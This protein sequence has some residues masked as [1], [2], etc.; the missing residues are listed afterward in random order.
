M[1]EG[2]AGLSS[3]DPANEETE[4]T[5]IKKLEFALPPPHDGV[6]GK[7]S[8]P[9][10]PSKCMEGDVSRSC[11]A[12][13]AT[14]IWERWGNSS[15]DEDDL[16]LYGKGQGYVPIQ[17]SENSASRRVDKSVARHFTSRVR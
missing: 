7:S 11:V 5:T 16:G 15:K 12:I 8:M 2:L 17:P 4:E 6:G 13:C 10:C 3:P 1:H 9:G 14:D